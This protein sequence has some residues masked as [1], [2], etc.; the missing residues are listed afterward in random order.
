MSSR[1]DLLNSRSRNQIEGVLRIL[2][3]RESVQEKPLDPV[4]GSLRTIL[5]ELRTNA[6]ALSFIQFVIASKA[7][8]IDLVLQLFDRSGQK[9]LTRDNVRVLNAETVRN[10]EDP[11]E[12]PADDDPTVA[13]IFKILQILKYYGVTFDAQ[14]NLSFSSVD[15]IAELTPQTEVMQRL[16]FEILIT[17][18]VI[19]KLVS[20]LLIFASDVNF[21]LNGK[22]H[23][24]PIRTKK[25]LSA[26]SV[27]DTAS[28]VERIYDQYSQPF[29][30]SWHIAFGF[31]KGGHIRSSAPIIVEAHFPQEAVAYLQAHF[32]E[33]L[34][35]TMSPGIQL[36]ELGETLGIQFMLRHSD[37]EETSAVPISLAE[38]KQLVVD[39]VPLADMVP[40]LVQ[41][42][43]VS[44]IRPISNEPRLLKVIKTPTGNRLG[45]QKNGS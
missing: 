21:K 35:P 23:H 9:I 44:A 27:Q 41:G 12:E 38:A 13:V 30:A 26:A 4:E 14:N 43:T 42:G 1:P 28:L 40:S 7:T 25:M 45:E 17:R 36:F 5:K 10:A 3:E 24:K 8:H 20:D 19:K 37:Q 39:K 11:D 22:S 16:Q 34:A 15:E 18:E 2:G 33:F 32:D 29:D 6:D 31:F